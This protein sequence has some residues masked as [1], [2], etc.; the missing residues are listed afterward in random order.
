LGRSCQ[1]EPG[2][3]SR[4]SIVHVFLER[5]AL[6]RRR[7]RSELVEREKR[8]NL[9]VGLPSECWWT[10]ADDTRHSLVALVADVGDLCVP[11]C[12]FAVRE[13]MSRS[14]YVSYDDGDDWRHQRHPH[15]STAIT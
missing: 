15:R 5:H 8:F 12:L 7:R 1:F 11:R 9:Q 13:R 14:K 3:C 10:F 2:F 6:V 4:P